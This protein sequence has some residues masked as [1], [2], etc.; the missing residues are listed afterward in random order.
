MSIEKHLTEKDLIEFQFKLSSDE[1]I[2]EITKHLES[3]SKCTEQMEKLK[4][5]FSA[6]DLL[7]GEIKVSQ[8]L[9]SQVLKQ[10]QKPAKA[11]IFSLTKS[12]WLSAAAV[13]I[14]GIILFSNMNRNHQTTGEKEDSNAF[15]LSP[16]ASKNGSPDSM[17]TGLNEKS[18]QGGVPVQNMVATGRGTNELNGA[19][20]T[21]GIDMEEQ[22][23]FAPA[24][25]IELNVLPKRESVQLTIYNSADL[26][27]VREK[28]NLTL[29]R[30]W[31]WLQLM[32]ANTLID[33]TSLS[34]EP[35][36]QKDKIYIQALVFPARLRQIGR[37]LIR[38][39][40][41]GQVPFEITY[42]TSGLS[43]R[44]FYMG[45]LSEDEKSM[46][47]EG[48]VRVSNNSG[49]D[50][51]N[52]QTRLIVGQV[53]MLDQIAA[54]AQQQYPYG[55]PLTQHGVK[56]SGGVWF[57]NS[58]LDAEE[59][60]DVSKFG[61]MDSQWGFFDGDVK[62]I[63]KEGLSEY[64]LYSIEGTE[65]IENQWSKRLLSFEAND[66]EVE[67]LY[68]YD[69]GRYGNQTIRFVK[70]RNDEDHNLGETPIP[71]G[72][73]KIYG[74]ADANGYL[75]YVGGTDVKYIPVN[76]EVELNLGEARLVEVKPILMD[77]KTDSYMYDPNE[78]ISGWNE[79]RTWKIEIINTRQI[80][81]TIEITR[82]FGTNYWT[83]QSQTPYEKHDITRIRFNLNIEPRTKRE[84]EYIVTTYHGARQDQF[85]Q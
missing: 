1:R 21:L 44:A 74:I 51:E 36:E 66:I 75:S 72:N 24:S 48:Y 52:A 70:F 69:E 14:L 58:R 65:T 18:M 34:L 39:E 27:L 33:P 29:K 59:K 55:S 11:K 31:N 13:L 78:N 32:W 54:L 26:T 83:L 46:E 50:Y 17:I 40:V 22:P 8:Q 56:T 9:A 38:S 77:F 62:G 28:R 63:I 71:N 16:T 20:G 68:K 12:A 41:S 45:T 85:N 3:C 53:H 6:L 25:A 80:P 57:E 30:G 84:I 43:W 73:V 7:K 42:L 61:L 15:S 23:Y 10:T 81:V 64:F 4:R 82:D 76:E 2:K 67:S 79:I 60:E 35:K 47:M 49:E 5:K 19:T 37:W